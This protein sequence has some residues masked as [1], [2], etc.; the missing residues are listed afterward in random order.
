MFPYLPDPDARNDV[1]FPQ[2]A[3]LLLPTPGEPSKQGFALSYNSV[4]DKLIDAFQF[5]SAERNSVTV[6]KSLTLGGTRQ[7][8]MHPTFLLAAVTSGLGQAGVI[9]GD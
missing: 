1:S 2:K 6:S 4:F 5:D 7:S 8:R 3:R 9:T